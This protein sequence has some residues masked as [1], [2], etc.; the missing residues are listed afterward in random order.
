MVRSPPTQPLIGAVQHVVGVELREDRHTREIIPEVGNH[1]NVAWQMSAR[2]TSL[3]LAAV[4]RDGGP[5]T[6]SGR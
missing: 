1:K 2:G 6:L 3:P 5:R 4:H